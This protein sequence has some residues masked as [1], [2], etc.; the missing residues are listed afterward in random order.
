MKDD[1]AEFDYTEKALRDI[2]RGE[3]ERQMRSAAIRTIVFVSL[4]LI[5]IAVMGLLT[6]CD[7]KPSHALSDEEVSRA[8]RQCAAMHRQ[9]VPVYGFMYTTELQGIVCGQRE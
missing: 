4:V 2:A 7:V 8:L 1:D 5:S 3:R 9:P 6:G